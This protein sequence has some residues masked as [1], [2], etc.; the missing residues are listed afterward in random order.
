[1]RSRPAPDTRQ[2]ASRRLV[3][4]F[5]NAA[6]CSGG[7]DDS[8]T[9][10]EEN[11]H[12]KVVA[13]I[14]VRLWRRHPR[15]HPC[16]AVVERAC[17]LDRLPRRHS[18]RR[19]GC[20]H[21]YPILSTDE[22]GRSSRS[23]YRRRRRVA[24]AARSGTAATGCGTASQENICARSSRCKATA[25]STGA[26]YGITYILK[27]SQNSSTLPPGPLARLSLALTVNTEY[28][29]IE[30]GASTDSTAVPH[31][32]GRHIRRF[33]GAARMMAQYSGKVSVKSDGTRRGAASLSDRTLTGGRPCPPPNT[34][35]TCSWLATNAGT[36]TCKSQ[37]PSLSVVIWPEPPGIRRN[38]SP[39]DS[40][41][42]P[43]SGVRRRNHH[44]ANMA[45]TRVDARSRNRR[46]GLRNSRIC[47]RSGFAN[48]ICPRPEHHQGI[49][50]H[51][52]LPQV[53]MREVEPWLTVL[54]D[55]KQADE[56]NQV[57]DVDGRGSRQQPFALLGPRGGKGQQ[58]RPKQN[59]DVRPVA[60]VRHFDG[61]VAQRVLQQI[62]QSH[63]LSPK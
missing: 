63:R 15:K 20:F 9:A 57:D 50:H 5:A 39:V 16:A 23:R 30:N 17:P 46:W 62:P 28:R 48:Q 56:A 32:S 4:G 11:S 38:T 7:A 8:R 45:M 29:V 25:S 41:S 60:A 58:R 12:E 43:S 19:M 35:C 10:R 14:R 40:L 51:Q 61:K 52:A 49:Q 6:T 24:P 44:T 55:V 31:S 1:M 26:M 27:Y 54:A 18:C 3:I 13:D 53:H 37:L 22:S 59:R 42:W 2:D 47:H 33:Q 34:R 36:G 21:S